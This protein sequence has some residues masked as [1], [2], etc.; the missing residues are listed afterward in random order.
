MTTKTKTKT[1]TTKLSILTIPATTRD[2][3]REAVTLR[4]VKKMQGREGVAFS[5]EVMLAG[6]VIAYARND[7]NGGCTFVDMERALAD[8]T[9]KAWKAAVDAM[10]ASFEPE[11]ALLD[12]L[13]E[14][15]DEK[16]IAERL[17][18]DGANVLYKVEHD[19]Q[20]SLDCYALATYI[21]FAKPAENTEIVTALGKKV[22]GTVVRVRRIF[23]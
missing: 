21:G 12:H 11:G 7:G 16:R 1:T 8:K 15:H 18:R 13:L 17:I 4:K 6:A 5:C 19:Y 22:K 23:A 9:R 14:R 2:D 10:Q 20:P 3:P